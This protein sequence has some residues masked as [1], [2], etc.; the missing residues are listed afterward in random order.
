MIQYLV[1][2]TALCIQT[3]DAIGQTKPES[4]TFPETTEKS[5]PFETITFEW[6]QFGQH[7]DKAQYVIRNQTEW[8]ALWR[9]AHAPRS[10]NQ[11]IPP[12]PSPPVDFD[13]E[14]VLAVFQGVRSSGGYSIQIS[15]VIQTKEKLITVV[16]QRTLCPG[17]VTTQAFTHPS[18]LVR[19]PKSAKPVC[20]RIMTITH[21]KRSGHLLKDGPIDPDI[22][23][24][25][26]Y[27]SNGKAHVHIVLK[28]PEMAE[29]ASSEEDWEAVRQLNEDVL[30]C[31]GAGE[32]E[33]ISKYTTFAGLAGRIT[34]T[35]L[36]RLKT[37]PN[38]IAVGFVGSFSLPEEWVIQQ[39]CE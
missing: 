38:L 8:D 23:K 26:K 7:R 12:P 24:E 36:E 39:D 29:D 31:M 13:R 2:S 18:H 37:H 35:G 20:F 25:F 15:E 6:V 32:F 34:R 1:V 11:E 10:K 16:K 30:T 33:A 9:K 22:Y 17:S 5:L 3:P 27:R 4:S 28:Q 14:M 21:P 19:V